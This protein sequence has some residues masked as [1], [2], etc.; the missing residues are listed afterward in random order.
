VYTFFKRDF[1]YITRPLWDKKPPNLYFGTT[2]PNFGYSSSEDCKFY[3]F[4]PRPGN[5]SLPK[6]FDVFLF[7]NELDLVYLRMQE[8]KDIVHKFVIVESGVTFTGNKK[9]LIFHENKA[10]FAEFNEKI[11]YYSPPLYEY[12]DHNL[13]FLQVE[14]IHRSSMRKALDLAGVQTGDIVLVSDADEIFRAE[15]IKMLVEC[16]GPAMLQMEMRNYQYSFEFQR[17]RMVRP[18]A[19]IYDPNSDNNFL[20][21]GKLTDTILA[22]AGWHC[23][24]CFPYLDDFLWKMDSWGH[25]ERVKPHHRTKEHIQKVICDGSDMFEI[26]VEEYTYKD[27]ICNSGPMPKITT[28]VGLPKYFVEN[29]MKFPYLRPGSCVRPQNKD[30]T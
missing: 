2:I 20:S 22:D 13:R 17:G 25:N 19:V 8:L 11:F 3:G 9:A 12:L 28:L 10:R 24:F 15:M 5:I 16:Q 6:V 21:H 29:Q 7:G 14:N 30:E 18:A 1:A 27:L 26:W 23:S 4:E